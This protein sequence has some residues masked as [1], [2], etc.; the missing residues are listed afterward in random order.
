MQELYTEK[1]K[2]QTGIQREKPR[3]WRLER[4]TACRRTTLEGVVITEGIAT[5][6]DSESVQDG[7]PKEEGAGFSLF[8]LEG[9]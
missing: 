8:L 7:D 6:R 5:T 2:R 4:S 3:L 9:L 1:Y